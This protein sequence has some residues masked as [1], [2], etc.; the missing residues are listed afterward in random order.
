MLREEQIDIRR[1][2]ARA[3]KLHIENLG[4]KRVFSD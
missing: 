4:K 2:R 3:A 1:Q